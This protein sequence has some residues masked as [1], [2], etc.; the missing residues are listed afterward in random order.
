[1]T[2]TL[3]LRKRRLKVDCLATIDHSWGPRLERDNSSAVVV[4]AYFNDQVA[5]HL[6][7]GF[8]PRTEQAIGPAYHGYVLQGGDVR[9]IVAAEGRVQRTKMFPSA[10]DVSLADETGR[11]YSLSGHMKNWAPWAPYT[12]VIYYSGL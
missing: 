6:L 9:G 12:S 11:T 7:A 8:D 4:Q 10:I 1:V 5:I 3:M 2:G